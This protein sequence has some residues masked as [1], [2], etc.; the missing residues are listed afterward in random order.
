[1]LDDGPFRQ[2]RI[3][4]ESAQLSVGQQ[5]FVA[6]VPAAGSVRGHL[7]DEQAGP[8]IA[9]VALTVDTKPAA[10]APGNER[11]RDVVSGLHRGH[12]RPYLRD[13]TST[14]VATEQREPVRRGL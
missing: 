8:D 2:D 1:D 12:A 14:L 4:G 6:K 10:A 13:D 7:P 3:F 9:D 5:V 11:K